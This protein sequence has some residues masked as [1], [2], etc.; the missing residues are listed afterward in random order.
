M[1]LRRKL[2]T[3]DE[4]VEAVALGVAIAKWSW[5]FVWE[6]F[7]RDAPGLGPRR[8]VPPASERRPAPQPWSVN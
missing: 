7:D 4:V 6:L 2:P 8:P 5:R 1:A 3:R